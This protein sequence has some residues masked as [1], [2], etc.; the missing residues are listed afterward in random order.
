MRMTRLVALAA[1]LGCVSSSSALAGGIA[2][3]RNYGAAQKEA[4]RTGKLIM[5]DFYTD[6][7]T[8]CKVLDRDVFTDPEVVAASR[9]FVNVKL[10]A[11]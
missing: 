5:V 8:F 3:A 9:K 4:R 11:E 10:N 7:C 6:W 2:W 1:L